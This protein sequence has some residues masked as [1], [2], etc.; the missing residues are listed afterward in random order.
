MPNQQLL[1]ATKKLADGNGLGD[2][3]RNPTT[4]DFV[5]ALSMTG[6]ES[7]GKS[8]IVA[9]MLGVTLTP[10]SHKTSTRLPLSIYHNY[11]ETRDAPL[12]ESLRLPQ[13][14]HP[15]GTIL[16]KETELEDLT[17]DECFTKINT[18]YDLV[19][20]ELGESELCKSEIVIRVRSQAAPTMV[21]IDIPGIV[22]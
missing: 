13:I 1:L 15:D 7:S 5:G 9:R 14:K 17:A 4:A 19:R 11:D 12:V 22:K 20:D 8:S 6:N 2:V 16:S 18:I 10:S 3:V 21:I